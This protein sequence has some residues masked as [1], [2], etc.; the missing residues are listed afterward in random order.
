MGIVN[1]GALPVYS[2]IPKDLLELIENVIFNKS[3][4][5]GEKLLE[6]AMNSTATGTKSRSNQLEWREKEV[7]E[8]LSYSLVKGISDFIEEDTEEAR[9]TLPQALHVIEGPLMSGM[10]VVGDLFGSGKMFLPQVIKSARV[11][12]KAVAYLIP[13]MEKEKEERRKTHP[14]E[15]EKQQ[16]TVLLATVKG[17]VHDIGKNIVGVVLGC[18]NYRVIDL[19]VMTPCE[20]ILEIAKKEKVD[21]IGLSGLITPSLDEMI[22]VAREM[23]RA[24]CKVPLLIG[25]ATTSKVHT[26]VKISQQYS[27]PVIHVLDASR[28]TVVVSNLLDDNLK[29]EFFLDIQEEYKQVA[30]S[31]FSNLKS[32]KYV[33]LDFAR[34]HPFRI[35]WKKSAPNIKKP[36]FLGTKVLKDFDLAKLVPF[37][38]WNPFFSTWELKGKFPNKGYPNIFKDENVGKA[39]QE[40]FDQ[41]QEMLQDIISKKRIKAHGIFGFYPANSAGDD[42]K[43]YSP[44][45]SKKEIATFYG[46]RQQIENQAAYVCASDFI[47]PAEENIDDYIGFFAVSAGFGVSEEVKKYKDEQLDD[48]N[49]I[50]FESLADR[51]AEAFAEY[52]HFEVRTNYWGYSPDE[53]F[54]NAQDLF[55]V[56]Y[57]GIRPAPGYPFQ[58]D[59]SEKSTIW[60]LLKVKDATEIEL[61]ESLAMLPA[62][63]VSGLYFGNENSKYFAV[64]KITKDQVTD[65]A[66]RRGI[67][68]EVAEKNLGP[69][70]S[71]L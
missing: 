9:K 42:I 26:A 3:P 53:K 7:K 12:K 32:R 19:G 10:N 2:D 59:H 23:E 45:N 39:A 56:K 44:E 70:L 34:K 31:Y 35:D 1:A 68:F 63:S 49:A 48:F 17:D 55:K 27:C 65:Y 36:S 69:I 64:G 54:S 60:S 67:P 58:P 38:D 30:E 18:N 16:G 22:F 40:L 11:M 61:T 41:A 57:R 14:E 33:E 8:R 51:L 29:D 24:G 37:I 43:V 25:G 13:F 4:E 52:L 20:K 62:A 15:L 28:S 6:Y 50:L 21:I 46:L 71:Y 47:A 66:K 5:A